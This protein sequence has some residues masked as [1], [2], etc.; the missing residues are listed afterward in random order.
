ML[1]KSYLH[2]VPLLQKE[3]LFEPH[4][5]IFMVHN[6]CNS[7]NM[8]MRA[9]PAAALGQLRICFRQSLDALCYK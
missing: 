2:V 5:V 8:G 7:C 9:L 6:L 3:K 4:R 1:L